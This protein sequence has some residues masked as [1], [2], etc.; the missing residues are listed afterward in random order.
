MVGYLGHP[1]FVNFSPRDR[2][3]PSPKEEATVSTMEENDQQKAAA[4]LARRAAE[5]D[6]TKEREEIRSRV[7]MLVGREE[8]RRLWRRYIDEA[9]G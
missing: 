3:S 1:P 8:Q 5:T 7:A 9:G 6:D 4:R 2:G